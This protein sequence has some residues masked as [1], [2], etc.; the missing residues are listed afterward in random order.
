MPGLLQTLP[1]LLTI[2]EDLLLKIISKLPPPWIILSRIMLTC[3]ALRREARTLVFTECNTMGMQ[4]KQ[5]ESTGSLLTA[6]RHVRYAKAFYEVEARFTMQDEVHSHSKWVVKL[7]K[8][9][10]TVTARRHDWKTG[11]WIMPYLCQTTEIKEASAEKT[12]P[13]RFI[14]A[15]GA[16]QMIV[17]S[18]GKCF[19]IKLVDDDVKGKREP[20]LV[21]RLQS[22]QVRR[23]GYIGG[24]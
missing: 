6:L 18:N 2:P 19:G 17:S 22:K 14:W 3:K 10:G 8:I 13:G 1:L 11:K 20:V 9:K 7:D 16:I 4:P 23:I 24:L 5:N 12:K 21:P 15:D